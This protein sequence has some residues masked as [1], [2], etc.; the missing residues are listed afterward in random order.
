MLPT[1]ACLPCPSPCP[2]PWVVAQSWAGP[3][4]FL[5]PCPCPGLLVIETRN[6]EVN[7]SKQLVDNLT[8]MRL[9]EFD[10]KSYETCGC[11]FCYGHMVENVHVHVYAY[12]TR[13]MQSIC[14]ASATTTCA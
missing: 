14:G 5:C 1:H 2:C 8:S 11:V 12:S 9:V 6:T 4:P 13:R 7:S 3:W 10:G